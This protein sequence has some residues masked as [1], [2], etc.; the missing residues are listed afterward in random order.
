MTH[1]A[2]EGQCMLDSLIK[3]FIPEVDA[4]EKLMVVLLIR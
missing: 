3:V 1:F 2:N 4:N